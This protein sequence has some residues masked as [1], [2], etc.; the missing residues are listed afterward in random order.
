MHTIHSIGNCW[1]ERTNLRLSCWP[2]DY[3]AWIRARLPKLRSDRIR[4]CSALIDLTIWC[5]C[6]CCRCTF[7]RPAMRCRPREMLKLSAPSLECTWGW[8]RENNSHYSPIHWLALLF[9]PFVTEKIPCR[10][11]TIS[12]SSICACPRDTCTSGSLSP[13]HPPLPALIFQSTGCRALKLH[14]KK[15]KCAMTG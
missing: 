8:R 12:P 6:G 15:E 1:I 14:E 10:P 13:L 7:A 11:C 4:S 5:T 9:C 2:F 3:P